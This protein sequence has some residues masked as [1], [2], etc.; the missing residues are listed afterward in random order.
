MR[1]SSSTTRSLADAAALTSART[2]AAALRRRRATTRS[3]CGARRDLERSS[4]ARST[5]GGTPLRRGRVPGRRSERPLSCSSSLARSDALANV[6][7]VQAPAARGRRCSRFVVALAARLRRRAPVRAPHPPPGA[8]R[9]PHRGR[10]LR[11]AGRRPRL[12]T[13]S[14]S[15]RGRS[16]ACASGS[17][18]SITRGASSSPT[19]RTSCAR[20]SS[21]WAA[22][23]SCSTTRS[24]TRTTRR[25][26]L[27]D[28]ARAGRPPDAARRATC[29]T[30]RG[31]TPGGCTSSAS[32]STS[33]EARARWSPPSSRRSRSRAATRSRSQH[34]R[35]ASGRSATSSGCCRSAASLVENALR[36]TP[37]G[38][39]RP[40]LA[41]PSGDGRAV[42]VGR[43][44]RARHPGRARART[45]SSAS[46]APTA[47]WPPAAASGSRSRASW[48]S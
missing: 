24:W 41:E 23:S 7:C 5:R 15:S 34:R 35:A 17:R 19:P 36:H 37:P 25:E 22:S 3:R 9:R 43:G 21:R 27:A 30:S 31:S 10:A 18:S 4:A 2:R 11:R 14:A 40:D 45:C 13:S 6:D 42:L 28:D 39:P 16:T 26:F 44:R 29:S 33:A 1:A 47:A 8:R 32:P 46:T 48:R 20:R 38:T 12:A